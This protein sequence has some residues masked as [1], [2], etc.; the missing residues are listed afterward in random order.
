MPD[1]IEYERMN[2]HMLLA[3]IKKRLGTD[4]GHENDVRRS[5]TLNA[6]S[7]KNL[8][9]IAV[10]KDIRL[11]ADGEYLLSHGTALCP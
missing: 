9:K 7:K 1:R 6:V 5:K 2:R 10:R 11:W 4:M 3:R 8:V